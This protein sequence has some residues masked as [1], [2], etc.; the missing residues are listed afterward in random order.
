[1]AI[2]LLLLGFTR[3]PGSCFTGNF[4]VQM[5]IA[6]MLENPGIVKINRIGHIKNKNRRGDMGENLKG[7]AHGTTAILTCSSPSN[8]GRIAIQAAIAEMSLK[9]GRVIWAQTKQ[10]LEDIEEAAR[11]AGRVLAIDGCPTC[12]VAKKLGELGIEADGH[13]VVTDLLGIKKSMAGV[14]FEE[15]KKVMDAID[16][17]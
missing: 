5:A 11:S 13:L 6:H 12:C 9:Q 8:A 2:S 15:V 3:R 16:R 17:L 7:M 4:G 14:K 1:M 10:P